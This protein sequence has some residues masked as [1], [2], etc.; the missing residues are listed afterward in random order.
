MTWFVSSETLNFNES[1]ELQHECTL[2]LLSAMRTQC[3]L[4]LVQN[5]LDSMQRALERGH[6][7]HVGSQQ[8]WKAHH[9]TVDKLQSRLNSLHI[10]EVSWTH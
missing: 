6:Y 8:L 7:E 3:N 9:S 10:Q 5:L 1:I 4:R 2:L